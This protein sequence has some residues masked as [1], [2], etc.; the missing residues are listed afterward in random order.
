MLSHAPDRIA[1]TPAPTA[2]AVRLLPDVRADPLPLGRLPGYGMRAFIAL[3]F[4]MAVVS[5]WLG[6]IL[7]DWWDQR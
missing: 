4:V 1:S 7:S 2:R 3:L 5:G 6:G